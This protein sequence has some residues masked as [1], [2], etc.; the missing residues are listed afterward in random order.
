[1]FGKHNYRA[2]F[3]AVGASGASENRSRFEGAAFATNSETDDF[4][5][6]N[7]CDRCHR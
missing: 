6:C 1:M 5:A 4:N 3:A 2:A 7:E